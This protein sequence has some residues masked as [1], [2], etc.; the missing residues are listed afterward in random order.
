MNSDSSIRIESHR[1]ETAG[2][3]AL[4]HHDHPSLL[5]VTSGRGTCQIE[6]Q[7]HELQADDAVYLPAGV[8]HGTQDL[9]G[10]PMA[11]FSI[12]FPIDTASLDPEVLGRL[13]DQ[14]GPFS[15]PTVSSKQVHQILRSLLHEQMQKG[16][17]HRSSMANLLS[18]L[19]I[20]LAR[21]LKPTAS[22]AL[23]GSLAQVAK[24]LAEIE[25]NSHEQFSL[26]EVARMAHLSQRQFSNLCNELTGRSYIA[27]LNHLRIQRS[28]Q[29][30]KETEWPVS[31]IAF[32][33]GFEEISTFYRA[34]R[35]ETQ[36]AP[37]HFR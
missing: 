29:L 13:T 31:A 20:L 11:I 17:F 32:E 10:S 34:F 30:L 33:V 2:S 24:V 27:H 18:R 12:E 28:I 3:V 4:H 15:V 16:D 25:E 7:S 22:D 36:K 37:G 5:Y 23:G 21:S 14:G 26:V 1:H 9:K 6:E 35:K 19:L 8:S